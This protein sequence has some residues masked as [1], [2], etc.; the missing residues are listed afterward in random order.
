MMS[1][2]EIIWTVALFPVVFFVLFTIFIL[3]LRVLINYFE[4]KTE[5]ETWEI[6]RVQSLVRRGFVRDVEFP[7]DIDPWTNL[8]HAWGNPLLW[9]WPWGLAPGDGMHFE[10]NE[11][12]DDGSVWPP[13]HIDQ[14]KP[15]EEEENAYASGRPQTLG[16]T[17]RRP[18]LAPGWQMKKQ[19]SQR[20]FYRSDQWQNFEGEK[21]S[22]FGVDISSI[23]PNYSYST[24]S[25][26]HTDENL[27]VSDESDREDEVMPLSELIKK[28]I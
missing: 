19:S 23:K 21:I 18:Q 7:Y 25:C 9:L 26:N 3:T 13:D 5:I 12:V 8:Y 17:N 28:S 14:D 20:D 15:S 27:S 1:K 10:K 16:Y 4:G 22:D 24:K 11:V 6:Q 2:R